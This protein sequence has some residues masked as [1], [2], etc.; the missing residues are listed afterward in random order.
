MK[1]LACSAAASRL[2]VFNLW[3]VPLQG[4]RGQ[5]GPQG[6]KGEKGDKVNNE[7]PGPQTSSSPVLQTRP[8]PSPSPVTFDL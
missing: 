1:A 2:W 7:E 5:E 8:A 3:L 6:P 4:E